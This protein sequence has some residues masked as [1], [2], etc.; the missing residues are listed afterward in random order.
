MSCLPENKHP[1]TLSKG[2]AKKAYSKR[3]ALLRQGGQALPL[4][5][6]KSEELAMQ[7][8]REHLDTRWK[9]GDPTLMDTAHQ[10][11][12]HLHLE[13]EELAQA[14]RQRDPAKIAEEAGDVLYLA[15]NL[16]RLAHTPR[17]RDIDS[18]FDVHG[19]PTRFP[20]SDP[21]RNLTGRQ[22]AEAIRDEDPDFLRWMEETKLDPFL[23]GEAATEEERYLLHKLL[24]VHRTVFASNPKCPNLICRPSLHLPW[25]RFWGARTRMGGTTSVCLG[26]PP[27]RFVACWL[28]VLL[29]EAGL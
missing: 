3:K 11:R 17:P 14:L 20:K 26:H 10:L 25:T 1:K 24:Y 28:S 19:N 8:M 15:T 4:A 5:R 12:K 27:L 7:A 29:R 23:I 6:F 22:R 21:R 2:D 13:L 16:V 18:D 9:R